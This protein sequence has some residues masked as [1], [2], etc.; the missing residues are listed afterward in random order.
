[1]P[2]ESNPATLTSSA[3]RA[4]QRIGVPKETFPG[5][6]RVATVPEVV[7]ARSLGMRVAAVSVVTNV[8][9]PDAPSRTDAEEVCEMAGA[10]ADG[11][12]EV[13]RAIANA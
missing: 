1:M 3:P 8:A 5:E 9:R 13:L 4:S 10:A 6:K 2:T 11:V 12:W 7:A